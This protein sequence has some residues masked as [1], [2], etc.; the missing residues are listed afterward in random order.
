MAEEDPISADVRQ[1]LIDN[2][3]SIAELEGL[4]LL[5]KET[6]EEWTGRSLAQRLYTT[7]EQA[8]GVLRRL[9]ALGVVSRTGAPN[10]YRFQ[11]TSAAKAALI[12]RV[13]DAYS[14]FLIRVTNL[15]HSKP[16]P[17]V[18]QF[19]DAFKLRDEGDE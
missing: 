13:A 17:K 3:D 1:F 8:D 4:M 2:I 15:I 9:V 6:G 19:A 11:P 7:E 16:N 5:S 12:E 18:Q 14:K 10:G